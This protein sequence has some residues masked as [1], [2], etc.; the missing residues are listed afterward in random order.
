MDILAVRQQVSALA[1]APSAQ[2]IPPVSVSSLRVVGG[3]SSHVVC[4]QLS[5]VGVTASRAGSGGMGAEWT[6]PSVSD[7]DVC[8]PCTPG[9]SAACC[10]VVRELLGSVRSVR[11]LRKAVG[12]V[13]GPV[14]LSSLAFCPGGFMTRDNCELS[15]AGRSS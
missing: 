6:C 8:L 15:V 4:L 1:D 5:R 14:H 7:R 3:L 11:C 12:R 2:N 13:E 10:P 9:A